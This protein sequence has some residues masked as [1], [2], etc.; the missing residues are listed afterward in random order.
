[1]TNRYYAPELI[2]ALAGFVSPNVVYLLEQ[3]Y[4]RK[5]RAVLA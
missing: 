3:C 1:M 5:A 2:V 4:R